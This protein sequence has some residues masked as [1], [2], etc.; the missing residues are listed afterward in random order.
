MAVPNPAVGNASVRIR[1]L[2]TFAEKLGLTP[3]QVVGS[4][5]LLAAG[6]LDDGR[7]D[8]LGDERDR[9]ARLRMWLDAYQVRGSF[10]DRTLLILHR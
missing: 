1:S 4:P 9:S 5:P 7:G 3:A 8:N 6:C 10:D 2:R